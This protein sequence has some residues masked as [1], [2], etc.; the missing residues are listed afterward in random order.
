MLCGLSHKSL[1][2]HRI[3]DGAEEV[4]TRLDFEKITD[5]DFLQLDIEGYELRALEGAAE[6][7]MRCKPLIQLELRDNMLARYGASSDIVRAWL[8]TLDYFQV[9]AQAGSDFVFECAH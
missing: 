1:G 6:T 8:E 3:I 9:S 5:L 7:I 4:M 2:S